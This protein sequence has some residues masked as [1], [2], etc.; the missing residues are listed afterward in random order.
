[1]PERSKLLSIQ[2]YNLGCVGKEGLFIELD[3]VLCLVGTNNTGKST[4]LR[5]YE[6]ALGTTTYSY[7]KDHCSRSG[8]DFSMVEIAVHIPEGIGNIAEKWKEKN[9]EN[10]VVK[11]KWIWDKTGKVER[12]TWDPDIVDYTDEGNASGLDTVFKSRLPVPF[13][14]GALQNPQA[15]LKN[16]L[17]LLVKPIADSLKIDIEN[18]DSEISKLLDAF[19]KQAQKPVEEHKKRIQKINDEITHSHN[20]I[21][22]HLSIDLNI[23]IADIDINPLDALLKGS[24]LNFKEWDQQIEW[25]QQ[26][27]GSQRALFW[28]LL[29]VR[30]RLQALSNFKNETDRKVKTLEKDIKKLETEKDKAKKDD[31]KTEKQGQIDEKKA[32]L[33][34][35][36]QL[37]IEEA[38]DEKDDTDIALPGYMLL[39]DEPEIALHPNAIR[40]A[41]EYLYDLGND[42]SW[43][44]MITTHSQLFINPLKDHTTIIRLSRDNENPTPKTYIADTAMFSYNDI[45][46]L[47]MLNRFDSDIA[48]MFF[49]Q[50]PIIIEGDT[51]FASFEKIYELFPDDY[52]INSRPILIRA[53]G[54]YSIIP[55]IKMLTHFKSDFSILH[56]SD[57]P[58]TK[59]GGSNPAWSA[60]FDIFSEIEKA[61]VSGVKVIHRISFY[62]FE[63][64]HKGIELDED[65]TVI[66]PASKEKPWVMCELIQS[67]DFVCKS[68]REILKELSDLKSS[69]NQFDISFPEGLIRGF[70]QLVTSTGIID[71]RFQLT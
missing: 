50:Y 24:K 41:S 18:S 55:I 68:V 43:Q 22:P 21:F 27:T 62:T 47:K 28:S 4:V 64:Q 8:D 45:E 1:M 13:R 60:N 57:F 5:A 69:Q 65:M 54:K 31:T 9:G 53:R 51:E 44:I 15:E 23:G 17:T 6:L 66:I 10:L 20:K 2:I 48:E 12:K 11:S 56:D 71:N 14:V 32:E 70:K 59:K 33:V 46:N 58:F 26:G 39:I 35:L 63:S 36:Q 38:F 61:R 37:N 7:D 42:P 29:Q 67:Y 30:S 16:L 34:G 25:D 52:P 3:N 49:G 40:A 19:T